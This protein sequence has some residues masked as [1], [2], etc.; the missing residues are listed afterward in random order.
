M[1]CHDPMAGM[2]SAEVVDLLATVDREPGWW[3]R[4]YVALSE[5]ASGLL[6]SL[7][8]LP[9]PLADGRTTRGPRGLL[10]PGDGGLPDGLEPLGLR[11][12]HSAA[13]HPLLR[14]LGAVEASRYVACMAAL[15]PQA[16]GYQLLPRQNMSR[17]L[18]NFI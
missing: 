5:R 4:L 11:V 13:A 18:R 7:G 2:R 1:I 17:G 15:F 6:E 16:P 10:L 3:H 12:V 8:S 9:V 14:R